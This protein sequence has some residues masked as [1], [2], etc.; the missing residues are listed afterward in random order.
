MKQLVQDRYSAILPGVRAQELIY[1]LGYDALKVAL[2]YLLSSVILLLFSP[3][4]LLIAIAIRLDSPGPVFFVQQRVGARRIRNGKLEYWEP[5]LFP[6]Y[7]FRTMVQN[8]DC[9]I[10]KAYMQAYIHNDQQ[11]MANIQGDATQVR[12]LVHDPRITRVGRLLRK[13]SFDELPQFWNVLRGEMS[14][15][16]PRPAIPYEL[17]H[18]QPWHFERLQCLPGVTG[19]WQVKGRCSTDFDDM[20]R[21]DIEY[22]RQRS[23]WMDL[24]IIIKTPAV[25]ITQKGGH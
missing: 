22:V 5:R 23:L 8:A 19:L 17:D 20:V 12:K 7:K 9:S 4:I 13:T 24:T 10:H 2:D 14:V 25:M 1:N 3:L 18:Y 15:V 6:C 16:G 11:A 21:L